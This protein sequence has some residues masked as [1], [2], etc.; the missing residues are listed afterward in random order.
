MNH[1]E[2][3][4]RAQRNRPALEKKSE[5]QAKID[6]DIAA[7]RKGG[8]KITKIPI[9]QSSYIPIQNKRVKQLWAKGEKGD[10]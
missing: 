9:G 2:I 8:G 1:I 7:F 6:S 10:G 5:M 3:I 4:S